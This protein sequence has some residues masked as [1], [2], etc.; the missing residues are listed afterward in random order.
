MF[1]PPTIYTCFPHGKNKVLTLSY[2]DGSKDD[3]RLIE[4][5]N[6]HGIK[7]TFNINAGIAGTGYTIPMHELKSVYEGHEVACHTYSHPTIARCPIEHVT[8]QILADRH[9]LEDAI[10]KPVRGIAYPNG[11]YSKEIVQLLPALGIKYARIVPTSGLFSIPQN[12]LEWSATCRHYDHLLEKAQ[13]FDELYKTQYLYMMSIWGH[14]IEFT[15]DQNWHMM[16][17]FCAFIGEK[18]DIWYATNI[19][20][21]DYLDAANRLQFTAAGNKAYNPSVQDIWLR[22]ETPKAESKIC[23]I[24]GGQMVSLF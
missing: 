11:S 23:C 7:G 18:E 3:Y 13:A 6:K 12:F 4:I 8:Q 19:E 10:G 9:R 14:S 16:E 2:D 24:P 5:M 1:I 17:E 21:V 15:R 20:I 22:V